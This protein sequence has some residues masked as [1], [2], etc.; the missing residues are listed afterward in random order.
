ML[1]RAD[2]DGTFRFP[3]ELAVWTVAHANCHL[4]STDRQNEAVVDT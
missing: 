1:R 2:F 4:V 3:S